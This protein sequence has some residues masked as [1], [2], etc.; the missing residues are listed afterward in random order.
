MPKVLHP[1]D[2]NNTTRFNFDIELSTSVLIELIREFRTKN[3]EYSYN[4]KF[5]IKLIDYNTNTSIEINKD[6]I[7]FYP[8]ISEE[9]KDNFRKRIYKHVA[10]RSLVYFQTAI[11]N[12]KSSVNSLLTD[13][14]RSCTSTLYYSLHKFI[15]GQMY[16]ILN[17]IVDIEDHDIK[18]N[19]IDHFTDRIYFK[20]KEKYISNQQLDNNN[21]LSVICTSKNRA[22]PF[23]L[24]DFFINEHNELITNIF[25][26]YIEMISI[27]LFGKNYND[28]T[29]EDIKQKVQNK[30]QE[31]EV[32]R[33]ISDALLMS[34]NN[35]NDSAKW[36]FCALSLRLYWLRQVADYEF[37]FEVK[38]SIREMSVLYS[39]VNELLL[40]DFWIYHESKNSNNEVNEEFNLN[41][42]ASKEENIDENIKIKKNIFNYYAVDANFPY[43]IKNDKEIIVFMTAVHTNSDFS[44][45][46]IIPMLNLVPEITNCGK[47]Y[48]YSSINQLNLILYVHFNEEG[49]W[50]FWLDGESDYTSF[51]SNEDIIKAFENFFSSI[52]KCS[53]KLSIDN[54]NFSFV[55]S[56]P[57][58]LNKTIDTMLPSGLIKI[59][60]SIS[61][62]KDWITTDIVLYLYRKFKMLSEDVNMIA[63]ESVLNIKE[64]NVSFRLVFN[65]ESFYPFNEII[66]NNITKQY[67]NLIIVNLIVLEPETYLQEKESRYS[68]YLNNCYYMLS[69][70]KNNNGFTDEDIL[71][72]ESIFISTDEL[73][74]LVKGY[75]EPL[76]FNFHFSLC[77]NTQIYNLIENNN[78]EEAKELLN[79]FVEIN[80][81]HPFIFATFG[82]WYFLNNDVDVEEALEK[83]KDFYE[84]SL[85]KVAELDEINIIDLQKKYYYELSRFYYYRVKDLT[86]ALDYLNKGF[87]LSKKDYLIDEYLLLK[88]EIETKKL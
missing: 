43:E 31:A 48:T 65:Q 64:L 50:T 17:N 10:Q 5:D 7:A 33:A 19:D 24:I 42:M 81:V 27:N 13:D 87:N 16:T 15:N 36:M 1:K 67:K 63:E 47:Y 84:K 12:I 34:L 38:T 68:G 44:K 75:E 18:V 23:L 70:L 80:N 2:I 72:I 53:E 66:T 60:Q 45:E 40:Y 39:T 55:V 54:S 61:I 9:E 6:F 59:N 28:L 51:F 35:K 32:K 29:D 79:I 37:D 8:P 82:F 30:N 25:R 85:N 22:N 78:F 26:P 74:I 86:N 41:T 3:H 73:Q 46:K 14:L 83:G 88:E 76:N 56:Q 49:R 57:I 58:F 4:R 52:M 69:N 20:F 21:Y 71:D 11:A 77:I 62:R